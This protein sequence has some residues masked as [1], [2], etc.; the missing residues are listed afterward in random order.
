MRGDLGLSSSHVSF[1]SANFGGGI[2][3][4]NY[5]DEELNWGGTTSLMQ[6]TLDHN[7]ALEGGGIWTSSSHLA[8]IQSRIWANRAQPNPDDAPPGFDY[9]GPLLGGGIFITGATYM[10]IREST[11]GG[12]SAGESPLAVSQP[13]PDTYTVPRQ[14]ELPDLSDAPGKNARGGGIAAFGA[15]F[16]DITNS[17]IS[18]NWADDLGG[19][20]YIQGGTTH[21]GI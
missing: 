11:I 14:H 7:R 20:I 1:N 19:G 16:A 15:F 21:S 2:F 3:D 18:G 6:T 10:V 4:E 17:T 9:A 8:V 5:R 12:N 13:G